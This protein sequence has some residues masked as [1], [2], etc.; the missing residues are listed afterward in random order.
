MIRRYVKAKWWIL[1][2]NCFQRRG[3]YRDTFPAVNGCDSFIVLNLSIKDTF[4]TVIDSAICRGEVVDFNSQ[5]L[6]TA[7]TFRDTFDAVNGCDSF[8]VLNLSI[9]DTFQTVI[10]SAICQGDVVDFN[11][12]ML[13]TAGTYRDTLGALNGCDSFIVLNLSVKDTFQTVISRSICR[14]DSFA[15]NNQDLSI[16]GTYRD[17]LM[18][19]NGCDSFI[20]LTLN[21]V[22]T[23]QMQINHSI[24]K[25]GSYLFNGQNLITSGVYR[26]TLS[27]VSGCD[28]FIV[29]NL[30][31]RDTFQTVIDSAICS[32]DV[33]DFNSQMLS[34]A[35]TY[36]DTFNAVNGCDSFIV[37]NLSIKDT[38]QTV[39][40]SAIC[41]GE[42]VEFNSQLLSTAGTYRDT[43]NAVNGCDSFIVLNLSIKECEVH[44]IKIFD[45]C[46][47]LNNATQTGNGQFADKVT[48]FSNI[49]NETWWIVENRDMYTASSPNPPASPTLVPLGTILVFEGMENGF[50]K[51]S[52]D[53]KH[54]D[55]IGFFGKFTN[56]QDTLEASNI[57]YYSQS[58]PSFT[59][60]S[61]ST[62]GGIDTL[63]RLIM[64][65]SPT[66]A[67][68]T[69][70]N[71]GGCNFRS[72]GAEDN[73]LYAD[74]SARNNVH[75]ICPPSQ[76][77][78]LF[79]TFSQFDLAVGDTLYVFEGTDTINSP[80]AKWNG[81]GVSQ[82]GGW[83]K[84]NCDPAINAS[85]CLTF[86]FKTNGDNNKGLGWR[87]SLSC[88]ETNITLTPPN[89]LNAKLDCK[90]LYSI[91][92]IQAATLLSECGIAQDS[93]MV[94]IYNQQGKICID[95]CLASSDMLT[96]TFGIGQ[97]LVV[98][99][100]K[101][102]TIKSTQATLTVQGASLVCNDTIRVPFGSACAVQLS[103]DMLLENACDTITDSLYYFI[104]LKGKDKN[105]REKILATGG[106]KGGNYPM[107]MPEM[108]KK[109]S[110]I[111]T[112]SIEKRY[113][114]GLNLGFCNNG[115]YNEKCEVTIQ[116]LDQSPP[117][118][119][120]T[121]AIDTFK[122]CAIDLSEKGLNLIKPQA[123]D[124]CGEAIVTF[125][126][127]II[128]ED[129]GNCDTTHIQVKW[130]A[131]DECDNT[132]SMTQLVLV[133]RPD[134]NDF[135]PAPNQILSCGEDD[136]N[137]LYNFN[138]TGLPGLK[139]GRVKNGQLIPADT[140]FLD[141][142][143]Y[144]CGYILQ[145]RD[146]QIAADCGIKL[147]RYWDILDWCDGVNGPIPVDTQL[148]QLKD[149]L[150]PTFVT[151]SLPTKIIPLGN[152]CIF[153]FNQL[154][155]PLAIANCISP[156]VYLDKIFKIEKNALWEISST[157]AAKSDSFHVSW[158]VENPC[159][160]EKKRDTIHQLILLKDEMTP[161]AKCTNRLHFSI[162]SSLNQLHFSSIDKGS[163]D[164]C[165][166]AKWEVSRDKI[167]W[168]E[169]V[170][171][172]CKDVEQEIPVYL[173]ITDK[174]GNQNTC[175]T[176]VKVE[177]KVAN[178]CE[179][180]L[181][182]TSQQAVQKAPV[183]GKILDWK[184]RP[185]EAVRLAVNAD[186]KDTTS[187]T[188]QYRLYLP[189]QSDY[190]LKP[191]KNDKP[192]NGLSTYDLIL[193]SKHILNVS[194][195][196]SPW[197]YIAA[198]V[199]QS[200]TI[201]TYDLVQ[202][203]QL[204]L[205]VK[206]H[207]PNNNSWRFVDA[208]YAFSTNNPL[209]EDLPE[210]FI[211]ENLNASIQK[212]FVAIKIG[213]VSG[214]AQSNQ[215]MAAEERDNKDVFEILVEDKD[216][217]VGETYIIDFTSNQIADMAG[218]QFT[219]TYEGLQFKNLIKGLSKPENFGLH[220]TT[221]NFLT[222]S[223]YHST[224]FS[225]SPT[226]L[227]FGIQFK[228]LR[229]SKLSK[230]LS[231]ISHPTNKEAYDKSGAVL[232]VQLT[233]SP[234]V[235]N[236][237]FELYQNV[238]NPFNQSTII[239]FYLPDDSEIVLTLKD[240]T[241][242]LLRIIKEIRKAGTQHIELQNQDLPKGV[243]YYQLYT[244]FGAKSKK[245]LHLD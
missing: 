225:L 77:Q 179:N 185:V 106:G 76:W 94:R 13:S 44:I 233:F 98:Y 108:V 61:T 58:C 200:G 201:S 32:G 45:P 19:I 142:T 70:S 111:L 130:I 157:I 152:E 182:D 18:A 118:F 60:D 140:I 243:L 64:N 38:F 162:G 188:G 89:N 178:I 124:N 163:Y 133:I 172:D 216:L 37:L 161:T 5:L 187:E 139:V 120:T 168:G 65:V 72:E 48:I 42:V 2:A 137:D 92:S 68:S 154:N 215:F 6:S 207:F 226:T 193:I 212:D 71:C 189:T 85:G 235:P 4:Q 217:I 14:G 100:L 21:I 119:T 175:W 88:E 131:K 134:I 53:L 25:G 236:R 219:L 173:R 47:C 239:S 208:D 23:F 3:T 196:E 54:I 205:N 195:F 209:A 33:V 41:R 149:T 240:K 69:L 229:S 202:I 190:T 224:D 148:I 126:E 206:D 56:G 136:E 171:F 24:C 167:N 199:N 101:S 22:D 113:Y 151:D 29:L 102:D 11:S 123:V 66:P 241:G 63:C 59:T 57:C 80:I 143:N 132:T 146:V 211:I 40:D 232:D 95:T 165:D 7:G 83:I 159:L 238:P 78:R 227:L 237:A 198:D 103:P 122:L 34:T 31:I 87:A 176:T 183:T 222:T 192:L 164:A 180:I 125:D 62:P 36:R 155:P 96:D 17:T 127:A 166:I 81:T 228:A 230:Q 39:I 73:T 129:G 191:Y 214:N 121:A 8:I 194:P 79:V 244:K 104:T 116:V 174:N 221:E 245:M 75:T 177:D 160:L 231:L 10:D 84:A 30:S 86:Q 9:K 112:A 52:I 28:S 220:K 20:I 82:T 204:I 74:T 1:I 97:Y 114:E 169:Y 35:G 26:D 90:A 203:R 49:S 27:S 156:R 43:F 158:I 197:Q 46:T 184:Q 50:C 234:S 144:T 51:Y 147:F 55:G 210:A 181:A 91:F 138:K 67:Q 186:E 99:K 16:S 135:V 128:I 223:W 141:T 12:Q 150:P 109:C 117:I 15:F 115:I 170:F 93:Q 242:R 145:K 105:G 218:Y 153:D 110:G 213:D 107:I